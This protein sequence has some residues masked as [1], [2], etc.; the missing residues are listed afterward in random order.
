MS[1][2]VGVTGGIGCGKSTVCAEF[3]K[4]G[5]PVIDADVV[6]KQLTIPGSEGLRQIQQ[7]F[8]PSVL[9]PDGQLNRG[10]M[11]QL[12]FTDPVKL[13]QLEDI[14]HPKIRIAILENIQQ[15]QEDYLIICVPLLL[16]KN[17]LDL[18]D[19]LLVVDIAEEEQ[20][21]RVVLRDGICENQARLV[22]RQ[23]I[24]R[25]ERLQHADDI[26]DNT[27]ENRLHQQIWRL[28]VKYLQSAQSK[29]KQV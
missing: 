24:T 23:Q 21:K 14:L 18:I 12:V 7:T 19:T 15:I 13:A 29:K 20:I 26:I 1:Y 16:E 8:G 3:S 28:H 2:I 17:Y 5:I 11:R 22:M 9:T 6:A 27:A 4:L 10:Q 25:Q